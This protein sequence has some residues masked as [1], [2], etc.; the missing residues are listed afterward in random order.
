MATHSSIPAWEIPWTEKPRGYSPWDH[1]ELAMTSRLNKETNSC[2]C[3]QS[4]SPVQLVCDP[5]DCSPS[6]SSVYGISRVRIL[7]VLLFPSP[8]KL[9]SYLVNNF[10]KT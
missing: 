8:G 7:D 4:L 2:K 10:N 1:K 3:S 9:I 6:G 5:M